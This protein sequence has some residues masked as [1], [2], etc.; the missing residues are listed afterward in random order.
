MKTVTHIF[1][2]GSYTTG[3]TISSLHTNPWECELLVGSNCFSDYESEI[4]QKIKSFGQLAEGWHFGEG[5]PASEAVISA[6]INLFIY[7]QQNLMNEAN[8]VVN[9]LPEVNGGVILS[10]GSGEDF[11]ELLI[12]S[13]L[14]VDLIQE[15]GIGTDYEII[16]EE[17]G[18]DIKNTALILSYLKKICNSSELYMSNSMMSIKSDLLL[19][20]SKIMAQESPFSKRPA[21][22]PK[23]PLSAIISRPYTRTLMETL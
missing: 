6:T 8:L 19:T 18:I 17:E 9:A 1:S 11:I 23:A 5:L 4:V 12:N 16:N 3:T 7:L 2:S 20:A 13:D 22:E 10:F 15:K 14:T 21:Q